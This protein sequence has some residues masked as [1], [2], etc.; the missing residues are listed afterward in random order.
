MGKLIL[1]KRILIF[2]L[3]F[4]LSYGITLDEAIKEALENNLEIKQYKEDLKIANLEIMLS[5][6]MYLP[7]LFIN[8]AYTYLNK[9]PYTKIP[10]FSPLFPSIEFKQS[11]SRF[12]N[13]EL[14]VNIPLF[15]GFKRVNKLKLANTDYRVKEELLLEEKRKVKIKVIEAYINVL[16]LE[17]LLDVLEKQK[18]A[19]EEHYRRAKGFYEEGLITKVEVLQTK[20]RLAEIEREIKRLNGKIKVAKAYLNSLLN[21]NINEDIN[22]E[23]IDINIPKNLDINLLIKRALKERNII[24]A[25]N[26]QEK[27][28]KYIGEINKGNFLPS[29]GLTGK[30]FYT[31]QYPYTSPKGNFSISIGIGV[32]FQGLE[33]YYKY[34]KTKEEERKFRFFKKNTVNK[35]ILEIKD[36][37][38]AFVVARENLKVAES[39]LS[40]AEEYYKKVVEQFKEQ[41]ASTTDFLNAEAYLTKARAERVIAY[42]QLIL[43]FLR[44]KELTGDIYE[45]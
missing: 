11:N 25:L 4:N 23:K 33:P 8:S 9:T 32:R 36:N 29:V 28:F 22:L 44:L 39:S 13:F 20:V 18:K 38:E 5:K 31:D 45:E 16:Q 34:L 2:I 7:E 17:T 43:T 6:N 41:I 15:L 42:Y 37:Y 21:R 40:E 27:E 35:I 24:K 3:L 12:L 26:Y 14:G 19:V 10:S 1:I 30:Y